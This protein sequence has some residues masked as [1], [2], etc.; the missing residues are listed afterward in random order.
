MKKVDDF[1]S[2]RKWTLQQVQDFIPLPM[3]MASAMYY[4]GKTTDGKILQVNRGLKE[5]RPQMKML[6]KAR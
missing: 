6:K 5:R 1:L 4:C 3:T 2:S